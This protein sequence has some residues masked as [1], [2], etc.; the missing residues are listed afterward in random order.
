MQKII[1]ILMISFFSTNTL[2]ASDSAQSFLGITFGEPLIVDKCVGYVNANICTYKTNAD[3]FMYDTSWEGK[4]VNIFV[5][6]T[7]E[8]EGILKNGSIGI[9]ILDGDIVE[10]ISFATGGY[11]VQ[12][13]A[14]K[15]L[16]QKYGKPSYTS[17]KK[18][19]NAFNTKYQTLDAGWKLA[20]LV[21]NFRGVESDDLEWGRVTIY[22]KA[23]KKQLDDKEKSEDSKKLKM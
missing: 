16:T 20:D 22:T 15:L 1:L 14:L 19:R 2:S 21:V 23:F 7:T 11:A 4:S 17:K 13:K 8:L 12:E 5:P 10:G 18:L 3:T 6:D 9:H